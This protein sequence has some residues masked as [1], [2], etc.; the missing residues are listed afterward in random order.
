MGETGFEILKK[1]KNAIDPKNT[2]GNGNMGLTPATI[3]VS[4]KLIE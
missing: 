1:I 4:S 3:S 2:F